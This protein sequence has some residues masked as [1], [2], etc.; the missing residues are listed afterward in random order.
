MKPEGGLMRRWWAVIALVVLAS[1]GGCGG[2]DGTEGGCQPPPPAE[3]EAPSGLAMALDPN[4]VTAG[5]TA[6]LRVSDAGLPEGAMVGLDVVWQCWDGSRWIDTYQ[7][8]RAVDPFV[9]QA[10]RLEPGATTIIEDLGVPLPS[11][12]EILIPDVPPGIYRI[13]DFEGIGDTAGH[14]IVEV[15]EG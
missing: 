12:A 1:A 14:L 2:I 5:M 10:I 7:L 8:V 11:N 3:I 4:P 15:I 13:W 6:I 9:A